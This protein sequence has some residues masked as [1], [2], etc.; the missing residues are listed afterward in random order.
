MDI[1]FS[2]DTDSLTIE[3]MLLIEDAQAGIR[4]VHAMT[5]LMV[6]FIAD[7][8]GNLIGADEGLKVL[9]KLKVSE[10]TNLVTAF[11]EAIKIKA[12]PLPTKGS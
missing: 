1:R 3:D 4:P 11:G 6:R 7:E 8:E 2:I 12:V 10:F 9:K 5:G